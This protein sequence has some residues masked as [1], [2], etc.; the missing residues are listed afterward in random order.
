MDFQSIAILPDGR[1]AIPRL[2]DAL[3]DADD[4]SHQPRPALAIEQTS[5]FK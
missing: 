2:D 3:R 4:R 5:S 1:L